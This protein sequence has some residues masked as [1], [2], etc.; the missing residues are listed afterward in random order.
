MDNFI[1]VVLA[2]DQSIIRQGLRYIIDA[3]SDMTVV[4]EAT[5]GEQALQTTMQTA[6]DLV[7][8]DIRMPDYAIL[9]SIP[10]AVI[11]AAALPTRRDTMCRLISMPAEIPAEVMRWPSSTNRASESTS[12]SG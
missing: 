10:R 6:P 3:Q 12:T 8:M 5:D 4:G 1:R 9:Y 7:L 2:E 11:A